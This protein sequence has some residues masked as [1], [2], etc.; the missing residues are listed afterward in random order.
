[1]LPSQGDDTSST[2]VR[3]TNFGCNMSVYT[4]RMKKPIKPKKDQVYHRNGRYY[5]YF[6][7]LNIWVVYDPNQYSWNI[8]VIPLQYRHKR[9]DYEAG[10]ALRMV[11]LTGGSWKAALGR[12]EMALD[13]VVTTPTHLAK[14]VARHVDPEEVRYEHCRAVHLLTR[15]VK[16]WSPTENDPNWVFVEGDL[17]RLF[18]MKKGYLYNTPMV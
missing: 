11:L 14:L 7:D 18:L 17:M 6:R 13:I 12:L 3:D 4:R 8:S 2:L 9:S 5:G 10:A 15:S 1:M 16:G